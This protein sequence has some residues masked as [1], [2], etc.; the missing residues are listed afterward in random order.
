MC[1]LNKQRRVN[2]M[3]NCLKSPSIKASTNSETFERSSFVCSDEAN[4][5]SPAEKLSPQHLQ[6]LRN[7]FVAILDS[8]GSAR[9]TAESGINFERVSSG[10]E[11]CRW[12]PYRSNAGRKVFQ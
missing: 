11:V 4:E 10:P 12:S 1:S 2:N 6:C 3:H 9:N 8:K 5:V 7:A